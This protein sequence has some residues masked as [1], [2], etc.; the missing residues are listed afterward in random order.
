MSGHAVCQSV[1][2]LMCFIKKYGSLIYTYTTKFRIRMAGILEYG[3]INMT[4][5][6][7]NTDST[8][9]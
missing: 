3:R 2:N 8:A 6:I 5:G 9:G 1:C 4:E 7:S